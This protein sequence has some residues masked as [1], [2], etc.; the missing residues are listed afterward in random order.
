MKVSY[1]FKPRRK[2]AWITM[3]RST[4]EDPTVMELANREVNEFLSDKIINKNPKVEA[5]LLCS[6][7]STF[8]M[9][10][11]WPGKVMMLLWRLLLFL[12]LA[13]LG[14]FI[15][16]NLLWKLKSIWILHHMIEFIDCSLC[17]KFTWGDSNGSANSKPH[18]ILSHGKRSC[19]RFS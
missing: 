1:R 18:I 7:C 14:F 5:Q 10:D 4:D 8:W 11:R 17:C 3:L 15:R 2:Q 16:I 19:L 12:P 13:I 9:Y 6:L